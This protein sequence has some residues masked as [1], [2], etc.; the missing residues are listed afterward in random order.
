MKQ[1]LI[2]T[3][4]GV[5]NNPGKSAIGV[6]IGNREYGKSLGISTNNI[7]E[8]QAVI[9]ALQKV[10]QLYSK[11]QLKDIK[12]IVNSDSQL[13][14]NQIN[15]KYKVVNEGLK[16]LFFELWNLKLDFPNIKFNFIPREQNERADTIVQRILMLVQ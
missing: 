8:Y 2:Y 4:G 16:S 10:K 6:I 15:G 13:M 9:F 11:E 1:L 7:A 14:V 12:I 3:D 5:I